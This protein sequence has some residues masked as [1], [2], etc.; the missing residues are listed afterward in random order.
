MNEKLTAAEE[1]QLA[2]IIEGLKGPNSEGSLD[3]TGWF[4][5]RVS[6][7]GSVTFRLAAG[8]AAARQ[9]SVSAYHIERERQ[10]KRTALKMLRRAQAVA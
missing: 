1:Q 2:I 5:D 4:A 10:Y 3:I 9:N 6:E 8:F 7:T